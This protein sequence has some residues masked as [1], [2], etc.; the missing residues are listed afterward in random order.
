VVEKKKVESPNMTFSGRLIDELMATV[1]R[2]EEKAQSSGKLAAQPLFAQP[3]LAQPVLLQPM[4]VEPIFV[5]AML[6][7]GWI[8]SVADQTDYDSRFAGVA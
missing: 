6:S 7:E 4:R 1:E 5:E 8:A 2:A 3:V